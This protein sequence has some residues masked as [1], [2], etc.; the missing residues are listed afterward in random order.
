[1]YHQVLVVE[2]ESGLSIILKKFLCAIGFKNKDITIAN[3]YV[4]AI[5]LNSEQEFDWFLCD[6]DLGDGEGPDL[7]S[8]IAEERP[9]IIMSGTIDGLRRDIIEQSSYGSLEKPFSLEQLRNEL[10]RKEILK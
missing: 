7:M 9:V 6:W 3:S 2:D 5:R 10:K 8:I 4:E 1:M